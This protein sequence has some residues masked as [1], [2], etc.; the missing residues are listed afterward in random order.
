MKK[1]R[2]LSTQELNMYKIISE[3]FEKPDVASKTRGP[4]LQKGF[5]S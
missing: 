5:I 1:I 2:P 3:Q 4:E